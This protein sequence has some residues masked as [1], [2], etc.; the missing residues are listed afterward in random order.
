[1]KLT[2]RGRVVTA[3]AALL[4]VACGLLTGAWLYLHSIGLV[5]S[6]TPGHTT[7]V[8][9]P[10]GASVTEIGRLLEA[11]GIV[12]SAFGFRLAVYLDGGGSGIEAGRYRLRHDLMARDA[13]DALAEG[14]ARARYVTVTFPEGSWLTELADIVGRDTGLS[15]ARFLR[16]AR[17]GALRSPLEPPG[18]HV[19]EGL[20][21][22]STYQVA[23]TD[24]ERSLLSRM[25]TEMRRQV[26]SLDLGRTRAQGYSAYDVVTV[27]S[28]VEAEAK[29]DADRA[30]IA[31]VVYNRLAA[32]MPLG[33]D[34]TV[35]YARG[36]RGPLSAPDLARDSP[37][38]TRRFP[39]LPPTPI[40]APG[41]ASLEA[42]AE[43]APGSWLYYVLADCSGRHAFSRSYAAFLADKAAYRALRC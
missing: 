37:Y 28:M 21:F 39:G 22:P 30:K 32:G 17:S 2:R 4:A 5:G 18:V 13:V 11:E 25:A 6:S 20:L 19:L 1:M 35:A 38:N 12:P 23:A 42:A 29:V 41:R 8:V 27:A 40:G 43:P 14:P 7:R 9:I 24:N 16:L 34:A 33:I 31:A 26:S 36:R 15:G 10:K 3:L